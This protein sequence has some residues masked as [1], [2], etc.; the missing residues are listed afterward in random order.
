MTTTIAVA[1]L[2]GGTGKS[3]TTWMMARLLCNRHRVLVIDLDPQANLTKVLAKIS[4]STMNLSHVLLKDLSLE[5]VAQPGAE[6]FE[7]IPANEQDLIYADGKMREAAAT[8]R[9]LNKH[10]I[11][12]LAK[13]IESTGQE[14]DYI[15]IDCPLSLG[16]LATCGVMAA[17]TVVIPAQ[18]SEM[19][20]DMV[21]E[22][23]TLVSEIDEMSGTKRKTIVL[24]T[25]VDTRTA[26]D[27]AGLLKLQ[28]LGAI[29]G[30]YIP[31]R[32]GRNADR[33]LLEAYAPVME[34]INV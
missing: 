25:I 31:E 12:K 10:P 23:L 22:T 4:N 6:G 15:L 18:P 9:I 14:Y 28:E 13:A 3:T 21:R 8:N 20:I 34:A 17:N 1:V 24:P 27:R 16:L 30:L 32:K 33:Q 11:F 2:K 5:C 7:V 19:P 26:R 29:N